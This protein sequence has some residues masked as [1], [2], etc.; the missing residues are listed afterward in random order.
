MIL[1]LGWGHL[2]FENLVLMPECSFCAKMLLVQSHTARLVGQ[3]SK[4]IHRRQHN[5]ISLHH[6][7][8]QG[9]LPRLPWQPHKAI[10]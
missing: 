9:S 3:L 10:V 5:E 4:A 7:K 1:G 6:Q 8:L 2:A